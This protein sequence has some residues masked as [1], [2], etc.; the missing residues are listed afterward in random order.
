[1]NINIGPL[2]ITVFFAII[3]LVGTGM[4]MGTTI[5]ENKYADFEPHAKSIITVDNKSY[6]CQGY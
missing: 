4:W 5:V 2:L 6:Y 3:F 1:M